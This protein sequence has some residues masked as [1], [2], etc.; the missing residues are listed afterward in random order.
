MLPTDTCV[1]SRHAGHSAMVSLQGSWPGSLT[2]F[3]SDVSLRELQEGLMSA[4]GSSR[5]PGQSCH[6]AWAARKGEPDGL[7]LL[8]WAA[9]F[10]EVSCGG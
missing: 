10:R 7:H 1:G 2:W 5:W 4:K 9:D 3:L 8:L 6:M